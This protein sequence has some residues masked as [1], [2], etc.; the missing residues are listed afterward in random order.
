MH[1]PKKRRYHGLEWLRF[2]MALWMV[3]YH[4]GGIYSDMPDLLRSVIGMGFF[5]TSTFFMLSGFLLAHVALDD[6]GGMKM[7]GPAFVARRLCNLYP[8]HVITMLLALGLLLFQY[9]IRPEG[10]HVYF[11]SHPYLPLS[12]EARAAFAGR[13]SWPSALGHIALQLTLLQAWEPRF[14]WL[15]GASW[16]ISALLFFYACFPLLAPRLMRLQRWGLALLVVWGL[17]AAGPLVATLSGAF[18]YVTVGMLHRNPLFRLP[19]FLTGILLYRALQTAGLAEL[20]RRFRYPLLAL[21][22]CGVPVGV[23]LL[24]LDGLHLYYLTHNGLLLPFQALVL[25][26]ATAFA[27]PASAANR[28][29]LQHLGEAALCIFALHTPLI[30]PFARATRW[31]LLRWHEGWV[32]ASGNAALKF[33]IPLWTMAIH[34]ALIVVL[35]LIMQR[36]VVKPLRE[37]L[38][39]RL[40]AAWQPT[41]RASGGDQPTALRQVALS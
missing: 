38:E 20:L 4:F 13:I 19:E 16:S 24:K 3:A 6:S 29:R 40:P 35:A 11:N 32:A 26:S 18:D 14:L 10:V 9:P 25:L 22:L 33:A 39:R 1:A 23:W 15:N 31:L 37:W 5:A 8:I 28:A 7:G 2:L 21:G 17:Y 12:D 36:Y 34:L 27:S 41:P 30:G